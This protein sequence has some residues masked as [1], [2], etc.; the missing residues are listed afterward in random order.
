M[1]AKRR[2]FVPD[3]GHPWGYCQ[4]A[5]EKKT[6]RK[7]LVCDAKT[8][9]E[10]TREVV[11]DIYT[12]KVVS[13]EVHGKHCC[14][15]A[16][17]AEKKKELDDSVSNSSEE[18]ND[19]IKSKKNVTENAAPT[20]KKRR[21][22][23]KERDDDGEKRMTL[24]RLPELVDKMHDKLLANLGDTIAAKAEQVFSARAYEEFKLSDAWRARLAVLEQEER[25]KLNAHI[26]SE[27]TKMQQLQKAIADFSAVLQGK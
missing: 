27:Q 17:I 16:D 15:A 4:H 22:R 26:S 14:T 18:E 10:A 2:Y 8:E 5:T 13:D 11:F 20:M 24:S 19:V 21:H 1:G 6:H 3:D 25:T 12:A 23:R 7:T 9:C